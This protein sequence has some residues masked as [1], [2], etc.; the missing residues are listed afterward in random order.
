MAEQPLSLQWLCFI[1]DH[2]VDLRVSK[3]ARV[4]ASLL[5]TYGEGKNI[6]VSMVKL[7]KKSGMKRETVRNARRELEDKGLLEDITGDPG[8]QSRTYRLA[9]PSYVVPEGVTPKV[10]PE[11]T[12]PG[13]LEDHSLVPERTTPG[14]QED[15]NIKLL[16]QAGGSS[17]TSP[18]PAAPDDDGDGAALEGQRQ[19]QEQDLD[20][21][22]EEADFPGIDWDDPDDGGGLAECLGVPLASIGKPFRAWFDGLCDSGQ[23]HCQH[24]YYAL[25]FAA[26]DAADKERPVGYFKAVLPGYVAELREVGKNEFYA[27]HDRDAA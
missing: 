23:I 11:R 4:L 27:R 2:G 14:P 12:T 3:E 24:D 13:P 22:Q 19:D 25:H 17:H 7:T 16:D 8:K 10:V 26:R 1:R 6:Y 18:S 20:D 15:H 5:P 9:V 21:D